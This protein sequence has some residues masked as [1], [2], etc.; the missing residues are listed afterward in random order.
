[1]GRYQEALTILRRVLAI[2]PTSRM[3]RTAVG[4]TL[5]QSRRYDE[6]IAAYTESLE[7]QETPG[8]LTFIGSAFAA[9]GRYDEALE[10]QQR[11]R[12]LNPSDPWIV[13]Y[14][15]Y[16][17][18]R[19]G[20]IQKAREHLAELRTMVR[21]EV[22]IAVELAGVY[23]GLGDREQAFFWLKRALEVRSVKLRWLR[24]DQRFQRLHRDERFRDVLRALGLPL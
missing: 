17:F 13:G 11:A 7:L 23:S 14:L 10:R 12:V 9:Q 2:H 6:A 15:A 19:S 16:T 8:T 18:A 3:L 24:G 21:D 5:L 4:G 22:A 20:R 1:M